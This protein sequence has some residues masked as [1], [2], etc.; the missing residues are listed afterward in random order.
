VGT[1]T[2]VPLLAVS[3]LAILG[4]ACQRSGGSAPEWELA[5]PLLPLPAAP[6]GLTIDLARLPDPPTPERVRLGRWL[7]YDTR[8]SKDRTVSCAT[9]H[10]HEYAF[11]EPTPVSTGVGG[12][13]GRRKSPS[14]LNYAETFSPHLF[15]WDGR[16]RSLEEQAPGRSRTR[17]RWARTPPDPD[18]RSIRGYARISRGVQRQASKARVAKAIADY[19]RTRMS[20]LAVDR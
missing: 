6:L 13:K 7:F 18:A 5:N 19:E 15:F 2:V 1:R 3:A 8:L 20:G 4:T 9:C 17:S 10:R 14:F 12:Q 11:S 16:A